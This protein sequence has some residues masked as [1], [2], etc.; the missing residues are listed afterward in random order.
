MVR[1]RQV[2]TRNENGV[3]VCFFDEERAIKQK[4]AILLKLQLNLARSRGF[5]PLTF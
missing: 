4:A 1:K 2:L 5:E 3:Q